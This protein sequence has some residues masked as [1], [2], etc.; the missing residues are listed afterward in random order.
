M[1]S[2]NMQAAAQAGHE[3]GPF[4]LP[5]PSP[6]LLLRAMR[7]M[8]KEE[9]KDSALVQ[10]VNEALIPY[11]D[12]ADNARQV[13][14]R[15]NDEQPPGVTLDPLEAVRVVYST[16]IVRMQ[17]SITAG[18]VAPPPAAQ[19]APAPAA[20]QA[21][22]STPAAAPPPPA[23]T[24]MPAAPPVPALTPADPQAAAPAPAAPEAVAPAPAA[25]PAA[26]PGPVTP[27]APATTAAAPQAPAT[28]PAAPQAVATTPADDDSDA[29]SD[30]SASSSSDGSAS[31]PPTQAPGLPGLLRPL[32]RQVAAG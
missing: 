23:A 12:M 14:R 31:S 32:L 10:L 17:E 25:P 13:V 22:A 19:G 16:I 3:Q 8:D 30:A 20:P 21:A 9:F 11:L 29:E 27:H 24:P 15:L 5:N 2:L 1:P 6:R 7:E 26:M 4:I 28:T 18:G